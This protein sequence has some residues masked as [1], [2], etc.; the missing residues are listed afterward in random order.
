MVYTE[1]QMMLICLQWIG[2]KLKNLKNSH[3]IEHKS[4]SVKSDTFH[5]KEWLNKAVMACDTHSQ[6]EVVSWFV[7]TLNSV[8]HCI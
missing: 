3:I 8:S 4:Y 2:A 1:L 6:A 7:L 5:S